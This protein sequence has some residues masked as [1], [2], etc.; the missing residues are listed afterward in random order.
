MGGEL[1]REEASTIRINQR[2]ILFV[3]LGAVAI[4]VLLHMSM[5]FCDSR[6]VCGAWTEV[7]LKRRYIFDLSGEGN[8]PTWFSVVQLAA[9]S[10]ALFA[11]FFIHKDRRKGRLPWLMLGALFLY[12]SLDEATDLH[13]LWINAAP[14]GMS[15][16]VARSGF[17][18]VLPGS[19]LVLLV[20][21]SFLPWLVRLPRRTAV[22][23]FI[24]AATYVFGGMG[25]E[26]VGAF[27][28]LAEANS[29]NILYALVATAEEALEM[30]GVTIMLY[31]VLDSWRGRQF[32]VIG[33]AL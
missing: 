32:I 17:D 15:L 30:I 31:A 10:L 18:W 12:L 26:A 21:L 24:A 29:S 20:S 27:T 4:L 1:G 2:I 11:T 5:Q 7:S 33:D 3:L 13:G 16:Q 6:N 14:E 23:F 28:Y 19:I 9:T 22:L 8:I 25:L